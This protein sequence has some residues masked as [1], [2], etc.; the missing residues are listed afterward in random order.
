MFSS[1]ALLPLLVL[2][3]SGL[4]KPLPQDTENGQAGSDTSGV[5]SS[6][7]SSQATDDGSSSVPASTT[8]GS[9]SASATASGGV[10]GTTAYDSSS[11]IPID[12]YAHEPVYG[13]QVQSIRDEKCFSP[14]PADPLESLTTGTP[15][16]LYPC[17]DAQN[18]ANNSRTWDVVPGEGAFILNGTNFALDAVQDSTGIYQLQL[19]EFCNC[20]E[21]EQFYVT[22]D[23]RIALN[24][25]GQCLTV[26][27]DTDAE[28]PDEA[29]GLILYNCTD[30]NTD[31]MFIT[32]DKT[33][34][35][36]VAIAPPT[37]S[38]V[39]QQESKIQAAKSQT[40]PAVIAAQ[41]TQ[42]AQTAQGSS[43]ATDTNVAASA[44]DATLASATDSGASGSA[45]GSAAFATEN[46]SAFTDGSSTI[47]DLSSTAGGGSSSAS[48]TNMV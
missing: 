48:A 19:K 40:D 4:A 15:V 46:S 43:T 7:Q 42:T 41:T 47:D 26:D 18:P 12:I 24:G 33:D 36:Y 2:A 38:Y 13:V 31:Q 44:A 28:G 11:S 35:D 10:D 5:A 34:Q 9:T 25:T 45:T 6:T 8:G 14:R 23:L 32:I 37:N 39:A 22:N 29:L 17:V 27:E 20:H 3:S 30:Q 21:P 16:D 1:Y